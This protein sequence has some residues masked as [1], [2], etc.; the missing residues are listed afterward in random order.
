MTSHDDARYHAFKNR[1]AEQLEIE[2][3]ATKLLTYVR[4]TLC[5]TQPVLDQ[6]GADAVMLSTLATRAGRQRYYRPTLM[7][8]VDQAYAHGHQPYTN[9]LLRSIDSNRHIER[10][11]PFNH[12]HYGVPR[13]DEDYSDP[14]PD[15]V[16]PLRFLPGDLYKWELELGSSYLDTL[17]LLRGENIDD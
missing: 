1:I 15:Y 5:S 8:L 14:E 11:N 13:V 12:Y 17:R 4:S 3:L 7:W 9:P 6:V 16:R 10:Y 2:A